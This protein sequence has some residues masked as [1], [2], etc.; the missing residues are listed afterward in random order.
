MKRA[1]HREQE[2]KEKNASYDA[3]ISAAKKTDSHDKYVSVFI[4]STSLCLYLVRHCVCIQCVSV[5]YLV[6]HSVK[7]RAW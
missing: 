3:D 2:R 5:F 7:R 1:E 6:L 4:F